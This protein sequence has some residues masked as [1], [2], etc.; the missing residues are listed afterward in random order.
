M[1]KRGVVNLLTAS[2]LQLATPES[3]K[4]TQGRGDSD[5]TS[6]DN[7][8]RLDRCLMVKVRMGM[9]SVGEWG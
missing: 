6:C 9:N 5:K 8:D 4:E 3:D 2:S 1:A 7:L